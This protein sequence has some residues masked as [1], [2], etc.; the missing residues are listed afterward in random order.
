MLLAAL[1]FTRIIDEAV[2]PLRFMSHL[3]YAVLLVMFITQW[4]VSVR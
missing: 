2:D 4:P 1:V 3:C